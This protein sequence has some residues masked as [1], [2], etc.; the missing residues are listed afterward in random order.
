[1]SFAS[2]SLTLLLATTVLNSAYS[3][4]YNSSTIPQEQ[5]IP[6]IIG[7]T[8]II[9]NGNN[10]ITIDID[11]KENGAKNNNKINQQQNNNVI[12]IS[13]N[14]NINNDNCGNNINIKN[15]NQNNGIKLNS[16]SV[17]KK[18]KYPIK[19]NKLKYHNEAL[20]IKY[21]QQN[22][23]TNINCTESSIESL[24]DYQVS[25]L[26]NAD[27]CLKAKDQQGAKSCLAEFV[28]YSEQF[29][30]GIYI[31]M[32]KIVY[33]LNST[34]ARF[35]EKQKKKTLQ[36]TKTNL[37]KTLVIEDNSNNNEINGEKQNNNK[38][39]EKKQT[40][41]KM[42][43]QVQ[44][45][46]I[47]E[48]RTNFNINNN[49]IKRDRKAL[50]NDHNKLI[51]LIKIAKKNKEI[52]DYTKREVTNI[53]FGDCLNAFQKKN[54]KNNSEE[55]VNAP[56]I[57]EETKGY[58]YKQML[59]KIKKFGKAVKQNVANKHNMIE[60]LSSKVRTLKELLENK[61]WEND[62]ETN[63]YKY[64]FSLRT[65]DKN[66]QERNLIQHL[67]ES[68]HIVQ[69]EYV[70]FST[71]KQTDDDQDEKTLI[72]GI[73]SLKGYD[74]ISNIINKTI[75]DNKKDIKDEYKK[76]VHFII[77]NYLVAPC[78]N[79][80]FSGINNNK[81][82]KYFSVFSDYDK[83]YN[84]SIMNTTEYI[85]NIIL[86]INVDE[87]NKK[88]IVKL[89]TI[90]GKTETGYEDYQKSYN[91]NQQENKYIKSYYNMKKQQQKK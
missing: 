88:V 25:L 15:Y 73:T 11:T 32:D 56:I 42:M 26:K 47:N 91:N 72:G 61:T 23:L 6:S 46:I 90:F 31:G 62:E 57:E 37:I 66:G 10:G 58:D 22:D 81:N 45:N 70:G 8:N 44:N 35:P 40:R 63:E 80:F 68:L 85:N 82:S 84:L 9:N 34:S 3:S 59:D 24:D 71:I 65:I 79:K 55:K 27:E 13:N 36:Q 19:Y 54:R 2:K 77:E 14:K 51:E 53:K 18:Y 52:P 48:L 30:N 69:N 39:K 38:K 17:D 21:I 74:L 20:P 83:Y 78:V 29:V 33:L 75:K 50:R 1:M 41:T 87:N 7:N 43:Q 76:A 64:E 16:N 4:T 28:S 60:A 49:N 89:A 12:Q 5:Y 86:Y 67:I